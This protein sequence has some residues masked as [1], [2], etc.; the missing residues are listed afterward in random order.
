MALSRRLRFEILRRDGHTCRYCGAMAP[1]VALTVDHVVPVTLG[2]S[3]DPSN[4]V[5]ACADCN[6]GKSSV[7]ADAPLVADVANDALRW[8]R[9]IEQARLEFEAE[10]A[11]VDELCQQFW[12]LWMDWT[13]E[14]EVTVPPPPVEPT[15][16]PL[17]D[18]WHRLM[19][20][21]GMHG[22]PISA[23]NGQLYVLAIRG[24]TKEVRRAALGSL[25][26][27]SKVLGQ[28]ME[29]V[30]VDNAPSEDVDVPPR[31]PSST[32]RKEQ[33]NIP[34][35]ENWQES[36]TRFLS[37]GLTVDRMRSLIRIAMTKPRLRTDETFRYF[38]GCA[39]REITDLQESARRI[40]ESEG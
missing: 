38:C 7:P 22:Q 31:P 35:D 13:Y 27:W 5:A 26:E 32:K 6:A 16:D 36:I 1:D 8:Q 14:V 20:W 24:Y 29:S 30:F 19:G 23:R 37:L 18:N 33:R 2:G 12:D 28:P 11:V 40:I 39:W 25:R 21:D 4:L 3:D 15:G 10:R 9:A 34:L 17:V